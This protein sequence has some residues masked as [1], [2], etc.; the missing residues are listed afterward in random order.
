MTGNRC[1]DQVSILEFQPTLGVA[2]EKFIISEL[3]GVNLI[4][5][6]QDQ[7]IDVEIRRSG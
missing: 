1:R 4:K 7:E 2:K 6:I 3:N 5:G